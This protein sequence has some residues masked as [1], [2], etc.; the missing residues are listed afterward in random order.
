MATQVGAL[1]ASVDLIVYGGDDFWVN[2]RVFSSTGAPV[3]LT[4]YTSKAEV[5]A[6]SRGSVLGE[7]D[8]TMPD[9]HTLKLHLDGDVSRTLPAACVWD[10]QITDANDYVMTLASGVLQVTPEVTR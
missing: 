9:V 10:V 7:F 4:P 8:I 1:P 6:T 3:D 2:L 5:R